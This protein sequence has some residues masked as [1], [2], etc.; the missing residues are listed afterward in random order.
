MKGAKLIRH[1]PCLNESKWR[2]Q[3]LFYTCTETQ[4]EHEA[5]FLFLP[6]PGASIA[7]GFVPDGTMTTGI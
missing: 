5:G 7:R 1:R 4:G 6:H 2:F 3:K